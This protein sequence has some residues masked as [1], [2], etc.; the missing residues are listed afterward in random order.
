ML[1]TLAPADPVLLLAVVDGRFA[2]LP[3]DVRAWFGVGAG[4]RVELRGPGSA[5]RAAFFAGLVRDV[6]RKPNEFAD[7]MPRRK[8]VL[9][10]LE[11][12]PPLEPRKPSAA[13]LALQEEND[14]RV[15]ALLKY[16]LEPIL[17]QLK[18]KFKRF[19][20]RATV[21]LSF[22]SVDGLLISGV[23]VKDEYVFEGMEDVQLQ[24]PPVDVVTTR[25]EVQAEPNGIIDI[26]EQNHV[27]PP[28][29]ERPC[30]WRHGARC[31]CP[32]CAES[33]GTLRHGLG[34]DAHAAVQGAILDAARL[35]R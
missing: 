20:K 11:V 21:G 7:G 25:V 34:A 33:S 31:P 3:R 23:F 35:P 5:E 9:E 14:Q 1:D 22:L 6:R 18:R 17:S 27:V 10:V 19:T 8:R 15:I 13:E 16:R 30:Q 24:N 26:M 28:S 2:D 4:G 29:G 32:A 12:A